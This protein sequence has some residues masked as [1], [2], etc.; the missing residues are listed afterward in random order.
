MVFSAVLHAYTLHRLDYTPKFFL[1]L[2]FDQLLLLVF[3]VDFPIAF[4]PYFIVF[5]SD[6]FSLEFQLQLFSPL[7]LV[8][9]FAF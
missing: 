1:S 6:C 4:L 9:I 5:Q 2:L 3:L 7:L 8:P